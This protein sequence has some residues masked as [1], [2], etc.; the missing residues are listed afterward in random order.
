[1]P[2]LIV[3]FLPVNM[4]INLHC[5]SKFASNWALL[6]RMSQRQA[7]VNL[8]PRAGCKPPAISNAKLYAEIRLVIILK[9]SPQI[10]VVRGAV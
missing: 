6:A 7:L 9:N 8:K 3:A 1:M 10:Q 4:V 5:V 2:A